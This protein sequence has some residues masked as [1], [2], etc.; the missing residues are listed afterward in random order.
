MIVALHTVADGAGDAPVLV[1]SG[2]LGS[3]VE[4][5]RPQLPH[6]ATPVEPH[7][8]TIADGI[9]GARLEIVP[10]GHLATI[11]SAD[12]VNELLVEHPRPA[13]S[14]GTG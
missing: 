8:R 7:A 5:W 1:L 6:L 4:M 10:G 11:E 9:P 2:S 14:T 3:S 13:S 12:A